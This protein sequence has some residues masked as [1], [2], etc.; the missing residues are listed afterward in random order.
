MF[1]KKF[2]LLFFILLFLFSFSLPV[3]SAES[4]EAGSSCQKDK[5][6]IY[7]CKN[8]T[9]ICTNT[10][11]CLEGKYCKTGG[12][13]CV[14]KGKP[15]EIIQVCKNSKSNVCFS[16][17]CKETPDK[18]GVCICTDTN[19]C[20]KGSICNNGECIK[21]IATGQD[22]SAN[23]TVLNICLN[24]AI[25]KELNEKI[26]CICEK[27]DQ[28]PEGKICQL[29][30]SDPNYQT[31]INL[32]KMGE[33][34]LT[35]AD[36]ITKNCKD[37]KCACN[38]NLHCEQLSNGTNFC[39]DG[40]CGTKTAVGDTC[41]AT[42]GTGCVSGLCGTVGSNNLCI[43]NSHDHCPSDKYCPNEGDKTCLEKVGL[44]TP[45]STIGDAMCKS[46]YCDP[47]KKICANPP[48]GYLDK[49]TSSGTAS[50]SIALPNLLE[51]TNPAKLASRVVG[52]LIGIAGAIALAIFVYAGII[53]LISQGSPDKIKEARSALTWTTIGLF[54]VFGSYAIL[55]Y[56]SNNFFNLQ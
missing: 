11:G 34:C 24:N 14:A 18:K 40:V 27:N 35:G 5:D 2:F 23:Q 19:Q 1:S 39:Q 49:K 51:E 33:S 9:C 41:P 6:C 12:L 46:G 53:L 45:C 52:F 8:G 13:E 44:N 4:K 55:N 20:T 7:K 43:C 56:I 48:D 15:G 17:S 38:N 22:C 37:N 28:C 3:F 29:T 54:L 21:Q 32:K 26:I 16:G 47:G 25:C 30:P 50:T 31:C 36:C 10:Q 42:G